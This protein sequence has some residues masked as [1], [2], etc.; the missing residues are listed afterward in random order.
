MSRDLPTTF[1]KETAQGIHPGKEQ[2]MEHRPIYI[3]PHYRASSKLQDRVAIITGGDS[4]I[5]RSVALLYAKEGADICIP[6]LKNHEDA[7]ETKKLIEQEGRKCL[8]IPGDLSDREQCRKVLDQTISTFNKL[9]ILVCH[10]GLQK[11]CD[12]FEDIDEDQIVKTF[13]TN[14]FAFFYLIKD[15]LKHLKSGSSIIM[16]SSVTSYRGH[17]QMVDYAST[18]GNHNTHSFFGNTTCS[19]RYQSQFS[20]SW[21]NLDSI[22]SI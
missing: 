12:N 6:Y 14:V 5:G 22:H 20:C 2:S 3:D 7:E 4:G 1:G 19:K 11:W 13:Q 21:S 9:D 8:V 15:A 16:T 17:P 10:H 18:N